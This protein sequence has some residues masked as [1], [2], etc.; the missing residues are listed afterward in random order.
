MSGFPYDEPIGLVCATCNQRRRK[1]H[2][3]RFL[4]MSGCDRGDEMQ[5]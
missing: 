2:A 4:V 5:R 3:R 1:L